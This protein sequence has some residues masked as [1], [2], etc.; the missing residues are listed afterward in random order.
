MS[1]RKRSFIPKR[2]KKLAHK[3]LREG[4]HTGHAHRAVAEDVG[5]FIDGDS[6]FMRTP[7]GTEV[8]HEEHNAVAIPPGEKGIGAVR[9][10]DHFAEEA[11]D[12]MD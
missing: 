10:F 12:V 6:L 8:V 4:E 5:L 2:A 9:E 11:R 3:V 7:S 1:R